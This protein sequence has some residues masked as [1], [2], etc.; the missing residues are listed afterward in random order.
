M[1]YEVITLIAV[2]AL[3]RIG[4][5]VAVVPRRRGIV[6]WRGGGLHAAPVIGAGP[7][8]PVSPIIPVAPVVTLRLDAVARRRLAAQVALGRIAVAVLVI[9]VVAR[10]LRLAVSY[11]FV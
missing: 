7:V 1:L 11:N 9:A 8:L 3:I 10:T 4:L 5:A 6:T 2:P